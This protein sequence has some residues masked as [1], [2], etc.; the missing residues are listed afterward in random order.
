MNGDTIELQL[1]QTVWYHLQ[2]SLECPISI[3][4]HLSEVFESSRGENS[5][6]HVSGFGN[7]KS[8]QRSIHPE[9]FT[10]RNNPN[11]LSKIEVK[12]RI[13]A[14]LFTLYWKY[15]VPVSRVIVKILFLGK[16]AI[17][18]A[19]KCLVFNKEKWEGNYSSLSKWSSLSPHGC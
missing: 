7:S 15:L 2:N 10:K 18:S 16:C 9:I 3:S 4:T 11:Q 19:S 5:V 1:A 13:L 8:L 12:G 14:L 17:W 6:R